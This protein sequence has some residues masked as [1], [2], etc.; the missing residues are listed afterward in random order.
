V[1]PGSGQYDQRNYLITIGGTTG[2]P[3][4]SIT[5]DPSQSPIDT[6]RNAPAAGDDYYI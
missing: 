3:T 2:S 4:V 5:I 1:Q 6:L